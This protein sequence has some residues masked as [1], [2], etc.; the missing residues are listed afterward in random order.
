M[1]YDETA[2]IT[3]WLLA[4]KPYTATAIRNY[5]YEYA[6]CLSMMMAELRIT[7]NHENVVMT[8]EEFFVLADRYLNTK[9]PS[10][11]GSLAGLSKLRLQQAVRQKCQELSAKQP[12]GLS[13]RLQVY[14]D[15]EQEF[16]Q[17]MGL[18]CPNINHHVGQC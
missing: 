7:P 11:T 3:E 5:V 13:G 2:R 4:D 18:V 12:D 15:L 8:A 1:K 17:R 6:G 16:M 10:E 14:L 9:L